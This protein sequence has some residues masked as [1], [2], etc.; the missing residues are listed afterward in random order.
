[1]N[2]KTLKIRLKATGYDIETGDYVFKSKIV[3]LKL[4]KNFPYG[5]FDNSIVDFILEDW[6]KE[7]FRDSDSYSWEFIEN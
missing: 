7:N 5:V 3:N 1:M 2:R 4:S 6:I